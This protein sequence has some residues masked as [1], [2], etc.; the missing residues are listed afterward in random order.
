MQRYK[1]TRKL[2]TFVGKIEFYEESYMF[3]ERAG[4]SMVLCR[5]GYGCC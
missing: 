3:A 5:K 4:G 1:K 2:V